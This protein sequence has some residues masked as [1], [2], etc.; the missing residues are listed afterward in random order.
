MAV[1]AAAISVL[2]RIHRQL[3]DLSDRAQRGVKLLKAREVN[4]ARLADEL[5]KAQADVKAAKMRA[6]QKQ[7]LLKSGEQK[8]LGLEA[9]LN[10]CGTNREYQAL[11]DQIAADRM[12]GQVLEDEILDALEKIDESQRVVAEAQKKIVD[13]K[14]ELAKQ[15]QAVNTQ[16]DSIATD[17]AR[18]RD[19]L[20]RAEAELPD[21]FRLAYNRV[22]NHKHEE[23]MAAV[24]GGF[25][26]GCNKQLTPNMLGELQMSRAVF[27]AN[28]GCILYTPQSG[29]PGG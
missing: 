23:A 4:L 20:A 15:Q 22:V 13:A 3:A 26:G 16:T 27:C 18:L 21:D 7:L 8:I 12:A 6:D 1:S 24:S 5:T 17:I 14:A 28:C 29:S 2:H 9:K 19:E 25:C 10:A 11:K